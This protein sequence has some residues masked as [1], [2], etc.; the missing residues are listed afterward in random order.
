MLDWTAYLK[1]VWQKHNKPYRTFKFWLELEEGY[2][3]E[4]RLQPECSSKHYWKNLYGKNINNNINIKGKDTTIFLIQYF[5]QL[6]YAILYSWN[7][8]CLSGT[9][10]ANL[11][12]VHW[13]FYDGTNVTNDHG[14]LQ[15]LLLWINFCLFTFYSSRSLLLRKKKTTKLIFNGK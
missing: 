6:V 3:W 9:E 7:G 8:Y 2:C 5:M 15:R 14:L 4:D 1:N 12:G 11:G 13:Q 10:I